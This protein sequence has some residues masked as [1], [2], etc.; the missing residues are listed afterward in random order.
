[1][2]AEQPVAAL[3]RGR[4]AAGIIDQYLSAQ[5]LSVKKA[6]QP[7][8]AEVKG[9]AETGAAEDSPTK[10]EAAVVPDEV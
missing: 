10:A 1:M 7:Q 8:A 3:S 5:Q 2:D 4:H 6:D 9:E